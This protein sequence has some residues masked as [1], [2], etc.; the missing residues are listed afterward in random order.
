MK[1]KANVKAAKSA[2]AKKTSRSG[3]AKEGLAM[4]GGVAAGAAAGSFLGPVGAAVGAVVGG[5][6]GMKAAEGSPA[7]KLAGIKK[8]ATGAAKKVAKGVKKAP[9]KRAS[10]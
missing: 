5:V 6:A 4:V 2:P 3:S 1:K 10:R 9:K 7:K 8:M